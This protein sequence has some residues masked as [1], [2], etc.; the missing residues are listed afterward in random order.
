MVK[1]QENW[2]MFHSNKTIDAASE[3]SIAAQTFLS[4]AVK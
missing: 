4:I 1:V 2:E 3:F